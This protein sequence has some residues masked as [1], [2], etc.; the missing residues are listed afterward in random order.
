[1]TEGARLVA[2]PLVGALLA[3]TLPGC[4]DRVTPSGGDDAP[5]TA[6]AAETEPNGS[7]SQATPLTEGATGL[8]EVGA[9]ADAD[10]W[11]FE[12]SAGEIVQIELFAARFDQQAWDGNRNVPRLRLVAPDGSVLL[13]HDNSGATGAA[14]DFGRHDL[15]VPLF[16]IPESGA[17]YVWITRDEEGGAGGR[18]ALTVRKI[19]PRNL[20]RE[21]EAGSS[22]NDT[23][24]NAEPI[25][26]GLIH[27]FHVAEESDYYAFT[28]S[29]PTLVYAEVVGHRN[30]RYRD[31]PDY[32]D[33]VLTLL[34]TDGLGQLQE[35]DDAFF[36]DS[37]LSHKLDTP[38][39]YYLRIRGRSAGVDAPYALQFD[40]RASSAIVETEENDDAASAE[41][42]GYGS[43][44]VG[45]TSR[46]DS[47]WFGF[48]ATAGD[49]LQ[50]WLF[51]FGNLEGAAADVE[52]DFFRPDG[53]RELPSA[54]PDPRLPVARTLVQE[55]GRHYV[56]I[57]STA[58]T[59]YC[60]EL[61]LFKRG[62][63]EDL[64]ADNGSLATASEVD[65]ERRASGIIENPDDQD[66]FRFSSERDELVRV[67]I[68]AERAAESDGFSPL[69][70]HGSDLEPVL[71][72]LDADG[73]PV[74]LASFDGPINGAVGAEGVV[75]GLA[76]VSL[77]FVAP[78]AGDYFVIVE[79]Q[80][81]AFGDNYHYLLEVR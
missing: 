25:E 63:F 72:V 9:A 7:R 33:P 78:S 13:T 12:A 20:Q 77:A 73:V 10:Y 29:E 66:V 50:L 57:R 17:Y 62:A 32:F 15:D 81:G 59:S 24:D 35:N 69:S 45:T 30:G 58:P 60:F 47:D 74:A 70:D 71:T 1:M 34:R 41:D 49:M 61:R 65:A 28:I 11:S 2:A 51:D 5:T 39:T 18:Y 21:A 42:I 6:L 27:G 56:R 48:E 22:E 76:T 79:D 43:V 23:F 44:V 14:W 64:E 8:G 80:G 75:D 53:T 38:G 54:S 26:P 4:G 36:F 16:R 46:T 40:L 31:S 68:Y 3:L 19:T 67:C 52:V 37:A 55:S